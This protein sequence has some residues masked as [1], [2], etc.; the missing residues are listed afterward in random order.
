M[1]MV[2]FQ[3]HLSA[4]YMLPGKNKASSSHNAVQIK[5]V[6]ETPGQLVI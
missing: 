4:N 1:S 3:I 5:N 2:L 6:L